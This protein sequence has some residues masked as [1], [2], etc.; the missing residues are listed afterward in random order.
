MAAR[1]WEPPDVDQCGHACLLQE[2]KERF[3]GPGTMPDGQHSSHG[4]SRPHLSL[5]LGSQRTLYQSVTVDG[6]ITAALALPCVV[7][8]AASPA[9]RCCH[10]RPCSNAYAAAAVRDPVVALSAG[11]PVGL[12]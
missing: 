3:G 2:S 4:L 11:D 8:V 5:V 10:T 7:L 9:Y 1:T 12:M 6:R